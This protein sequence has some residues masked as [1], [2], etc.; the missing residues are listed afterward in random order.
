MRFGFVLFCFSHL[1]ELTDSIG[2]LCYSCLAH[3][4][5][6]TYN[7]KEK[8]SSSWSIWNECDPTNT[9][10][11]LKI[12]IENTLQQQRKSEHHTI[13]INTR[14]FKSTNQTEYS[15]IKVAQTIFTG[16]PLCYF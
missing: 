14:A 2:G 13:Y 16:L 9:N 10:S 12:Q 7:K 6:S 11:N 5:L 3:G 8:G 1:D 15:Y 4:H